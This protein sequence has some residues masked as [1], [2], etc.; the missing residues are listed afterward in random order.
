MREIKHSYQSD[1]FI[2]SLNLIIEIDGDYWHGN[3]GNPRFKVLNKH[4]LKTKETDNLRTKELQEKGFKV[5][6][7]WESEIE[8]LN[9]QDFMQRLNPQE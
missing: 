8:K 5:L 6:R 1:I 7:L 3:T 9:L 2:P 4:Q